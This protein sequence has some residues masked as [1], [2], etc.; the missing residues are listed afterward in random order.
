MSNSKKAKKLLLGLDIGTNSVGWC[1]TDESN[2]II[3]HNRKSLWGVRLFDEANDCKERREH[4]SDR[5]RLGR[6]KERVDW[7]QRLFANEI[8]KVDKTF[9]VRLNQS[10]YKEEDRS[11]NFNYTLFNDKEYTDSKYYKEYPTI[12][13][14]RKHLVESKEKEDIRKIYLAMH[15][16]IKYRGN[17]LH[18]GADFKVMEKSD[19]E[20][21]F[22]CLNSCFQELDEEIGI[23][24]IHFSDDLFKN[25]KDCYFKIKGTAKKK[26]RLI[27]LFQAKFD[28]YLKNAII[29]LLVGSTLKI[30]NLR[31]DNYVESDIKELNVT[32]ENFENNINTLIET[33][34]EYEPLFKAFVCCKEIFNYFLLGKLIGDNNYLCQAMVKKYDKFK[35]DLE[36]LKDYVKKYSPDK[37]SKIFR[38]VAKDE[39]KSFANYMGSTIVGG[40]QKRFAKSSKKEFYKGLTHLLDLDNYKITDENKD[41]PASKLK[42]RIEDGN[43]L[44]KLNV[45]EN[46]VLPYQLNLLE[47]KK[48]LDNQKM[49]Y[50]FLEEKD[51]DGLTVIDKIISILK[52]KIPYYVGPLVKYDENNP[53]AKYSW[54]DRTNEKIYP[55]NFEK[56]VNLES[57]AER[58]IT[59]MLNKCTYL[60]SCYCIPTNS[61]IF[62]YYNVL[63]TLNKMCINGTAVNVEQK[64]DIIK[65]VFCNTRKPSK[66]HLKKYIKS[67]YGE[68]AELT[69][70]SF[71]KKSVDVITCNMTSFYDFTNIFGQTF[72]EENINTI[73]D[74]IRDIAVFEDKTILESRLRSKYKLDNDKIKKIKG[75]NYS[76]FGRISKELLTEIVACDE[77]GEI[78]DFD[79]GSILSIME[80]T[81]QNLQE[82]LAN[83]KYNFKQLIENYNRKLNK[84]ESPIT[85][86]EFVDTTYSIP[87]MKRATIQTYKIIEEIESI[88]GRKIDEYYVECTRTNKG[89]KVPSTSRYERMKDLYR[90]AEEIMFDNKD[91]KEANEKLNKI[92]PTL[93]QSDK[94]YL[95][96]SQFGLCMYSGKPINFDNL[97]E[98][99]ID[100][101]IPQSWIKDD[102]LNNRVLVQADMNQ[103]KAD[104]YP[105]HTDILFNGD[106][107]KAFKFYKML[108]DH[109]FISEEKYARLVRRDLNNNELESFVNRQLVY[110]NQAVK[111]LIN[112]INYFKKTKTFT[113]K[114]VYSKGENVSDYRNKH[115]IYKSRN[116]NNFHHAHDAYL[117]IVIGRA[118][119]S[120][121][122]PYQSHYNYI[123]EMHN[124]NLTTNVSK[125]LENDKEYTKKPILDGQKNV[126][127]DYVKTPKE[128][129]K[130]IYDRH[131]ILVT[132]RAYIKEALFEKISILPAG[133]GNIPVKSTGPLSNTKKYGGFKQMNFGSY[134]IIK[135]KNKYLLEA[136][137]TF[138]TNDVESYISKIYSDYEIKLRNLKINTIYEKGD[139][140]FS[141][142]GKSKKSFYICNKNE[143]FFTK[144]QTYIIHKIEKIISRCSKIDLSKA[145]DE[146]I[147]ECGIL[148][149]NNSLT[150][151]SKNKNAKCI[152]IN[153]NETERLY[154]D[155]IEIFSRKFYD[156]SAVQNMIDVLK[157]SRD[158]F[159]SL[160]LILQIS[161]LL[162]ILDFL[163]CNERKTINLELI[164]GKKTAGSL[165]INNNVTDYSIRFESITGLKSK[166]IVIKDL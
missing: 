63:S 42:E 119:D 72:V 108:K 7:L 162:N 148:V 110:T 122:K 56:V 33:Y 24:E 111:G 105:I 14:L 41:T 32:D 138:Y 46:G 104:N 22:A 28:Y 160:K 50:P 109:K 87:G 149:D 106:Y 66:I 61:I 54:I 150:I 94:Y 3:K 30:K 120:Y 51:E 34:S 164:G 6:I 137:P 57:S 10:M 36:Y 124:N 91:F 113:P 154:D 68:D 88:L 55:W 43:F 116:T 39:Y 123:K 59:R 60:P 35:E 75:L 103:K 140:K 147:K 1:V 27:E 78:N 90:S 71:D 131:D 2:E 144:S 135:T 126:V 12:Y 21:L 44:E 73:E 23:Q 139:L 142:T 125:I 29:P 153:K 165:S 85:I 117:N 146:Q 45:A 83:E 134:C 163:K 53:R 15:H 136:I 5:R 157:S 11:I 80:K 121:F 52:F 98:Y 158:T 114:I 64:R 18:E 143:R 161:L 9:F 31:I 65:N 25:L 40:V 86:E 77:N 79:Y 101:I 58:F 20:Q 155:F 26:E 130:N 118:I 37:Y 8:A 62:S 92:D 4:R 89:K 82:I 70:S 99:Q 97:E 48:I 151:L 100:H 17:F 95:Y 152:S 145:T 69:Y 159:I 141:I 49:Y 19:A 112:A 156:F 132:T 133:Q 84:D 93:F 38:E 16:L 96:F 13:H 127:W 166:V 76:G 67:T 129:I 115:D 47:I 81:N 74:I 102:S 128:I 107:K